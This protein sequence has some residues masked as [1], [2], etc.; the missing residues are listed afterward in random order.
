MAMGI[1]MFA[2]EIFLWLSAEYLPGSDNV[3]A[4]SVSRVSHDDA[5]WV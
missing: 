2:I 5:E 4:D 1:W 3:L